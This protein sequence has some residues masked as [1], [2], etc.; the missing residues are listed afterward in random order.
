MLKIR[1]ICFREG[2][3]KENLYTIS[4]SRGFRPGQ[5]FR[6]CK[7]INNKVRKEQQL[8]CEVLHLKYRGCKAERPR[9]QWD[10]QRVQLHPVHQSGYGPAVIEAKTKLSILLPS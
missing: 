9:V 1:K 7:T 10:P 4:A 8:R 3:D 2:I 5:N 6:G